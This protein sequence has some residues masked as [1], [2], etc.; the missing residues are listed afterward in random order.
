MRDVFGY[1]CLVLFIFAGVVAALAAA[2]P[3]LFSRRV[4]GGEPH[5]PPSAGAVDPAATPPQAGAVDPAVTPQPLAPTQSAPL[6]PTPSATLA[7][8]TPPPLAPATSP[9][10]EPTQSAPPRRGVLVAILA[11]VA[12]VAAGLAYVL[13]VAPT[14]SVTVKPPEQVVAAPGSRVPIEV[15]NEGA[16]GGTFR[17]QP[18]LDDAEIAEVSGDVAAGA[19]TMIDVVLPDDLA[20]GPH[21]LEIDGVEYAFT[22][23]TPPAYKVGKLKVEPKVAKVKSDVTVTVNVRN[24]GEATGTYPGALTA[25]GKDVAA[26]ATEIAGGKT[27]PVRVTFTTGKAGACKLDVGG[28]KSSVMVVKTER[29]ASGKVLANSLGGG[30]NLMVFQNKYSDD[31]MFCLTASASAKKPL[32]AV[33]VRGRKNA[34]VSGLRPGS[35]Y[36]F[37]SV[38]GDWNR[39]TDD[40][41]S[42]YWRGRFAKPA[43]LQ[44]KEWTSSSVDYSAR[45]IYT[46]HYTQSTRYTITIGSKGSGKSAPAVEVSGGKFPAP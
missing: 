37:Y 34:T 9:L 39:F 29:P 20:A 22:A 44:T 28:S 23:L 16:L 32:L 8:A 45:M 27:V 21:T 38:G 15:A 18:T 3:Q 17:K 5:T 11:A 19:V 41:L 25:G 6:A 43:A 7:P 24:T 36:V 26:S 46:T 2:R 13:L 35:Y 31:A 10:P 4:A 33:Y 12:V 30:G 40:F 14:Y 42:S 1:V